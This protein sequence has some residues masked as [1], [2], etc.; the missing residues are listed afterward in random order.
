MVPLDLYTYRQCLTQHICFSEALPRYL[1]DPYEKCVMRQFFRKSEIGYCDMEPALDQNRFLFKAANKLMY[2]TLADIVLTASCRNISNNHFKTLRGRGVY[3]IPSNCEVSSNDVIFFASKKDEIIYLDSRDLKVARDPTGVLTMGGGDRD[4]LEVD[5]LSLN[6]LPKI[7]H[8]KWTVIVEVIL[9]GVV[10]L[11]CLLFM[12][13]LC[14]MAP[15]RPT[16]V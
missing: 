12:C 11:V 15:S 10:A 8:I 5:L 9:V 1:N 2:A 4:R 16:A 7:E 6:E 13:V 14:R 3:S